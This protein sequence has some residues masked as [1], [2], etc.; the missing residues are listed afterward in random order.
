MEDNMAMFAE[1]MKKYGLSSLSQSGPALGGLLANGAGAVSALNPV[2]AGLAAVPALME[3]GLGIGQQIKGHQM[4]KS[5]VRPT[6]GIMPSQTQALYNAQNMAGGIAPGMSLAKNQLASNNAGTTYAIQ[7]SGGGTQ[8]RLAALL[9]N[10]R[11]A[12]ANAMQLGAQ[13]EAY[14]QAMQMNLQNQLMQK[15]EAEQRLFN[16]NLDEP[17]RNLTAMAAAKQNAGV[18]NMHEGANSL[19]GVAASAIK[20]GGN[21]KMPSLNPTVTPPKPFDPSQG[22]DATY[23]FN[24]LTDAQKAPPAPTGPFPDN[25]DPNTGRFK[26]PTLQQ[27]NNLI[28]PALNYLR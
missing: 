16:Y 2:T 4:A 5:A 6:L 21:Q 18:Q 8:D 19:G 22:A 17:Y 10:S 20:L 11:N 15:A 3:M 12:D 23:D 1:Y 25:W 27:V 14:S 13:Q 7:N 28:S 26:K 9:M 24:S